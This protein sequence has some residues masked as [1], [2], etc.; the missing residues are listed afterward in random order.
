[1]TM[2]QYDRLMEKY[3]EIALVESVMESLNWDLETYMPR[4]GTSLRSNQ[5]G[6]LERLHHRMLTSNEL[7]GLLRESEKGVKSLDEV[8]QRNLYLLRREHDIEM[9]MREDLPA[10]LTAQKTIA[11]D[12]W[13]KAKAAR[14]WELFEPELR[15]LID[16]SI[17]RAEATMHA[18]GAASVYDAMIDDFDRG[19]TQTQVAELLG[20]LRVSLLPLVR[21][22]QDASRDVDTSFKRRQVPLAVQ[23]ELV[24]DATA[25]LGYDTQSDKA[26]GRIDETEHPF[27]SGYFDDVRVTVHYYED[28]P[29]CALYDGLH[30]AGHA[31][32]EQNMNHDWMYQPV[33]RGASEGMHEAMSRFAENILG[34]S[35]SFWVHYLPR[36]KQF[37]GSA[38]SDVQLDDLLRAINKVE[39]SKTRLTADELTYSLH[40]A[41]RF[42]IERNLFEGKVE[43]SELPQIWD[44]L[45]DKYLQV[46][47]DHDGEGVLQDVH[48]SVG[49]YGGFQSYAL[50]NVYGGMFLRKMEEEN[51]AWSEEV[52]KG[53]PG[54]AIDWLRDRVQHWGAMYDPEEL[55]EKVTGTSVTPEPFVQY[56]TKKYSSLWK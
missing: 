6:V 29:L 12:A 9:S 39:P 48:W 33:G 26:W 52:E 19:M 51:S 32:Y 38:F 35:R 8:H 5:L 2:K 37:T 47:F 34:R 30:E 4:Q 28:D 53:G 49:F 31:L 25:L 54:V 10:E 7:A 36:F 21:K 27:T 15:K 50:G 42:E 56:L 11:W 46:R 43:V 41:I 14:K 13:S 23:R 40:I 24:R 1:M 16:L 17:R 44:D 18:R 45:Y 22:Y 55:V 20:D 3:R